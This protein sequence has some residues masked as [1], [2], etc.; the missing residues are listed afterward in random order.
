MKNAQDRQTI[1][2]P[3]E[4][5]NGKKAETQKLWCNTKETSGDDVQQ[6]MLV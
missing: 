1:S 2:A 5:R 3:L 6:K 4:A